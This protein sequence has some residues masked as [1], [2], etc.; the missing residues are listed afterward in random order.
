MVGQI[1]LVAPAI[2]KFGIDAVQVHLTA[3]LGC[4]VLVDETAMSDRPAPRTKLLAAK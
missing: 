4:R 1:V 2:H 3:P